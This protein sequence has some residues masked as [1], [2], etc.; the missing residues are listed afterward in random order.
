MG[1]EPM[2]SSLRG[3]RPRPLDECALPK[4]WLAR[5]DSNQGKRI[6]SPSCYHYTTG[7]QQS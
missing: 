7:Q 4:Y 5:L 1:F 6:Q 3:T 2:I